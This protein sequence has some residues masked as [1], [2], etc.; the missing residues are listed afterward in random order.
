VA[1]RLA[2]LEGDQQRE[3]VAVL[4][5]Q[6]GEALQDLAALAGG[7]PW[8]RPFVE[9]PA[10]G[11]HRHIDVLLVRPAE[12]HHGGA[13]PRREH[14]SHRPTDRRALL[15]VHEHPPRRLQ[16]VGAV[17]P[18]DAGEGARLPDRSIHTRAFL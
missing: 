18:V 14:G 3:L 17:H 6:G 5:H 15:A 10:R 12:L 9:R 1:D 13:V 16:C 4:L 11:G 2:H 7:Q 8:P